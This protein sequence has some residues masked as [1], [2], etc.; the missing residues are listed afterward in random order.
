[1]AW[2][3]LSLGCLLTHW[4]LCF[5]WL[6]GAGYPGISPMLLLL[7]KSDLS[8]GHPFQ[9]QH[10]K[11]HLYAEVSA[12]LTSCPNTRTHH[13]A[14]GISTWIPL[15]LYTPKTELSVSPSSSAPPSTFYSVCACNYFLSRW[16]KTP[17]S[18]LILL[19]CSSPR[20]SPSV[21]PVDLSFQNILKSVHFFHLLSSL[22]LLKVWLADQQQ[23]CQQGACKKCKNLGVFSRIT[24]SEDWALQ[25]IPDAL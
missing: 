16:T 5:A 22:L 24:N 18:S 20:C 2:M 12:V 14:T 8:L 21:N 1:M 9:S 23:Q 13:P 15:M 10:F 7:P 17:K 4:C 6:L 25:R 3:T 11:F 19:F